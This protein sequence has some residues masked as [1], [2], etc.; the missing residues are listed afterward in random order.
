[1][2]AIIRQD[3]AA[4]AAVPCVTYPN[5]VDA[6]LIETFFSQCKYAAQQARSRDLMLRATRDWSEHSTKWMVSSCLPIHK[7]RRSLPRMYPRLYLRRPQRREHPRA[8]GP[9]LNSAASPILRTKSCSRFVVVFL[10]VYTC[11]RLDYVVTANCSP[12]TPRHIWPAT[13]IKYYGRGYSLY[14]NIYIRYIIVIS[15]IT[16]HRPLHLSIVDPCWWS[17]VPRYLLLSWGNSKPTHM[18]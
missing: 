12:Y 2:V 13:P 7:S 16:T 11:H 15:T 10:H 14:I 18:R 9:S 3:T 6:A 17:H 5:E 1:M 8:R 4:A